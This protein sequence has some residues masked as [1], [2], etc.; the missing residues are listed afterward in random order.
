MDFDDGSGSG[1]H[2]RSDA[3]RV[4]SRVQQVSCC[5]C[6]C[7]CFCLSGGFLNH[8]HALWFVCCSTIQSVIPHCVSFV[9]SS[10]HAGGCLICPYARSGGSSVACRPCGLLGIATAR[11]DRT[12]GRFFCVG[13]A[14]RAASVRLSH[15]LRASAPVSRPIDT[16]GD[17]VCD[18]GLQ[19]SPSCTSS[20]AALVDGRIAPIQT[21]TGLLWHR[22]WWVPVQNYFF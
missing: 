16:H 5:F 17:G 8:S 22:H 20:P 6:V 10:W 13:C 9:L 7:R 12:A 1:C 11:H 18:D 2:V 21:D 19:P 3:D 14:S 4:D 15:Q